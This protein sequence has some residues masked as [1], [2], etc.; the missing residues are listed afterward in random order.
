M[1]DPVLLAGGVPRVAGILHRH[2]EMN[3]VLGLGLHRT[4]VLVARVVVRIVVVVPRR[5]HGNFAPGLKRPDGGI[6]GLLAHSVVGQPFLCRRVVV[7]TFLEVIV[8]TSIV[9]N[10]QKIEEGKGQGRRC[11]LGDR[12]D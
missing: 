8:S 7:Y 10:S 4:G 2:V 5:H 12:I 3:N 1:I 6:T 9:T 11:C